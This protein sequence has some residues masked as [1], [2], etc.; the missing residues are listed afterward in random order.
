MTCYSLISLPSHCLVIE[1]FCQA[2]LNHSEQ[3]PSTSLPGHAQKC[4]EAEAQDIAQEEK[5][6]G[7][8]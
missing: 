5:G 6:E 4:L 7:L 2:W 1:L 3:F 8:V